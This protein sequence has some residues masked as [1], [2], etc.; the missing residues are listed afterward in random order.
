M[1][2]HTDTQIEQ[3]ID[4]ENQFR[5]IA[6]RIVE[7]WGGHGEGL[8]WY[9]AGD[10]LYLNGRIAPTAVL[11][12]ACTLDLQNYSLSL[13][14]IEEERPDDETLRVIGHIRYTAVDGVPTSPSPKA[15][16][17]RPEQIQ[18]FSE[19]WM[20]LV[21]RKLFFCG[22]PIEC[23]GHEK[24]EWTRSQIEQKQASTELL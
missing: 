20:E 22:A 14:E 4:L 9:V 13:M 8:P 6:Q 18:E 21:R 5:P 19:K 7:V 12:V 15:D 11:T 16:T 24:L 3:L 10:F 17:C 2:M 23:T 1:A